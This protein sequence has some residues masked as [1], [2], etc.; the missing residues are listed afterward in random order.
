MKQLE[1]SDLGNRQVTRANAK[2]G[3]QVVQIDLKKIIIRKGFNVREDYGDLQALADSIKENG[4]EVPG[5]VDV[6]KN[7]TFV[8][9]DGH[10]RFKAM[11]LL[12]E[13]P[14]FKAIVNSRETTEEERLIQMFTTQDNKHLTPSEAAVLIQRLLTFGKNQTEIAQRI[15]KSPSYVSQ[16][17]SFSREDESVKEVVKSGKAS[18]SAVLKTKGLI[19]NKDERT[20]VI[21][22]A[23]A[24]GEKLQVNGKEEKILAAAKE[25]FNQSTLSEQI[26]VE[27]LTRYF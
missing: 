2:L 19:K 23:A 26:I 20:E 17:I 9:T 13:K 10:R 1:I 12:K 3:D 7:G 15:G 16:M 18:V 27:I 4:Q 22:T 5:R 6:L 8:L 21:T 14:L 24:S 11:Q 25:I